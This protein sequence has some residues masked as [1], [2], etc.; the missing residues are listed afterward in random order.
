MSLQ[1]PVASSNAPGATQARLALAFEAPRTSVII[2]TPAS[3]ANS[4]PINR[5]T[6]ARPLGAQL[7]RQRRQP[8]GD[9]GGIIV[10][11]VVDTAAAVLDRRQQLPPPR[12]RRE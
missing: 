11:N 3:P 10:H 8:L 5:G 12:R 1:T 2:T 9:W 4:R 6:R 7:L